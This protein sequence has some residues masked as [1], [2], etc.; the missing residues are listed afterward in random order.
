MMLV[1]NFFTFFIDS[2]YFNADGVHID[3]CEEESKKVRGVPPQH[4][5]KIKELVKLGVKTKDIVGDFRSNNI[6]L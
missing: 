3:E 4:R 6:Q 1:S 5:E 2:K